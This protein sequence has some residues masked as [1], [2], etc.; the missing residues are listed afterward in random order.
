[1]QLSTQVGDRIRSGN[2]AAMM[3]PPALE[4]GKAVLTPAERAYAQ[5]CA[6]GALKSSF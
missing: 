3:F 5:I 4:L 1:M 6:L 2:T